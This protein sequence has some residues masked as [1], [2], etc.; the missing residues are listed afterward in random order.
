MV[1]DSLPAEECFNIANFKP[2]KTLNT[3]F[4]ALYFKYL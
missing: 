2:T 1:V 3:T 4:L